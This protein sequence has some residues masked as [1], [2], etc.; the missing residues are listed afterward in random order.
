[1]TKPRLQVSFSG[2]R[3]SGFMSWWLKQHMSDVYDMRFV[4]ANTGFEHPDTLRFVDAVDKQFGLDL[5]WVE[6]VV[7]LGTRKASTHRVV[8]YD[9]ASRNG[10]PFE[11]VVAKYGLP[12]RTFKLC[13]RELKANTMRS[14]VE[15]GLG[16]GKDY[17]I[18]IGI[19]ADERRRVSATAT[20]QR[21]VYPLV[22]MVPTIKDDVLAFFEGRDWDLAIPER[23][24]NCLTCFQ[25]SDAKL[26]TLWRDHPEHFTFFKHLEETYPHV[27]PNNVPGPRKIFRMRRS[28][29]DLIAGFQEADTDSV[30][31]SSDA[32]S[33]T[34]SE[35]CELFEMEVTQ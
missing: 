15:N 5:T 12:N 19:R 1:M 18:A 25:K 14:F 16:W 6:A 28:T 13:T 24:G 11:A 30:R 10:E 27:G 4:F 23:E 33:G 3:T 29:A 2:G 8:T 34:C 35:S 9:T 7:H 20:E 31:M 32:E 17:E 26:N 22:D 21:I